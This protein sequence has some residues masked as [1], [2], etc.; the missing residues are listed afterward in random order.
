MRN[1]RGWFSVASLDLPDRLLLVAVVLLPWAFGGIEIWAYRLAGLL[2]VVA[3]TLRVGL[4]TEQ[5]GE[6]F[7]TR[8]ITRALARIKLELQ[9]CLYLGNLDAQRDWEQLL[10]RCQIFSGRDER[11]SS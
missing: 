11:N 6:T 2:I 9:D 7:V 1:A 8:K 10:K 4:S 5:R 3:A